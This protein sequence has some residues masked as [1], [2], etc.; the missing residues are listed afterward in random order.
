MTELILLIFEKKGD[1][2]VRFPSEM[3]RTENGQSQ[4]KT[5][6]NTGIAAR[7]DKDQ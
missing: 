4:V 1:K 2:R 3:E 7:T 5:Y 6:D